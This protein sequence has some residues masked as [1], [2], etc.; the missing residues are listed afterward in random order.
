MKLQSKKIK[1]KQEH[2]G[3]LPSNVIAI[4]YLKTGLLK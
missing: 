1:I 4:N 2:N 3:I